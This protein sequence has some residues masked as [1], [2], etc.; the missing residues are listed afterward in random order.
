MFKKAYHL[1]FHYSLSHFD[2]Q[3]QKILPR[4]IKMKKQILKTQVTKQASEPDVTFAS[5]EYPQAQQNR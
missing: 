4:T 3:Q 5:L 2:F 1:S